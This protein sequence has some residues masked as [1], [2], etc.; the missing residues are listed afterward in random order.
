MADDKTFLVKDLWEKLHSSEWPF[1]LN[2]FPVGSALVGGAIR[3]A[4]LNRKS[5]KKDLDFVIP[6]KA[7]ELSQSLA[8]KY[9]GTSIIL[10]NERDVARFIKGNWTIDIASQVGL[11]LEEDLSRRDFTINSIAISFSKRLE[12]IDPNGGLKDLITKRLVTVSE[13]NIQEDPL[14]ILRG[15]RLLAQLNFDLEDQTKI[16]FTKNAKLLELVSPERIKDEIE[17]LVN[18]LWADKAIICL[19]EIDLLSPWQE[20]NQESIFEITSLKDISIFKSEELE[21]ALPLIRLTYLLSDNGFTQLRFS[22]KKS[23]ICKLLRYWLKKNKELALQDL[24]ET[25]RLQLHKDLETSL[26]ALILGMPEKY[27]LTWLTRWRDS[28]DPLF[29][30]GSPVDG[31]TLKRIFGA[32]EGPWIGTLLHFL[33][34]ERAF[35]RLNNQQEALEFARLWWQHNNPFCD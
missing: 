22:K 12:F 15:F 11:S 24:N 25:E 27:R 10:D 20:D 17:K 5:L 9:S 13:Q 18:G 16:I 19:N 32:P 30:P 23:H 7:V 21:I 34:K 29:H 31:N 14:R 35:G 3:D 8:K 6:E 26:P 4:L 33:C 28:L 1:S 2:D